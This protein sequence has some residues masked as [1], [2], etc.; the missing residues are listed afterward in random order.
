[1][2][3]VE[4]QWQNFALDLLLLIASEILIRFLYSDYRHRFST[5]LLVQL[6]SL[7]IFCLVVMAF[8]HFPLLL[9]LFLPLIAIRCVKGILDKRKEAIKGVKVSKPLKYAKRSSEGTGIEEPQYFHLSTDLTR[10]PVNVAQ[11][12]NHSDTHSTR[13]YNMYPHPVRKMDSTP[14][15]VQNE[16]ERRLQPTSSPYLTVKVSPRSSPVSRVGYMYQKSA[17]SSNTSTLQKY[18]PSPT[19]T[20]LP[21]LPFS[22]STHDNTTLVASSG[23]PFNTPPYSN[24]NSVPSLIA[25][26]SQ[27]KPPGL[28]NTGNICFLVSVIHCLAGIEGFVSLLL[29]FPTPQ[30]KSDNNL[31]SSL[32]LVI[33][34]CQNWSLSSIKPNKLLLAISSLAPHLVTIHGQSQQD[35]G[36]FLLWLLDA[37]HEMHKKAT[38]VDMTEEKQSLIARL[39]S[40]KDTIQSLEMRSDDIET[41][42]DKLIKLSSVD[43]SILEQE[44]MS[45]IYKMCCGQLFEAREC[46]QC[47]RVSTNI[48]YYTILTL[49]VPQNTN[50]DIRLCFELFSQ[51]ESLNH[52][53]N[54]FRC[55]C[56]IKESDFPTSG[57]RLAC[58]SYLPSHL[59]IQLARFS[60]DYARKQALKNQTP[61]VFPVTGLDLSSFTL[62]S[63]LKAPLDASQPT[64]Y[65]LCGFCVHTGARTT[66]YG[67]YIA[68]SKAKDGAWYR[69]DDNYVSLVNDIEKEIKQP[70]VSQNTYLIFYKAKRH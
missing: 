54:M 10:R 46:Q 28:S 37:L 56:T 25:T 57:S 14:T 21:T 27:S 50:S 38:K 69:F 23:L 29:Q 20:L 1:M 36:E 64:L 12:G 49:P 5:L 59:I 41:Y 65:D 9:V 68:Y 39:K 53:H 2:S 63:K 66:S 55:T 62:N 3:F 67:H 34:Q 48:E 40:E 61:V 42:R 24:M 30:K 52:S 13:M 17:L 47:K 31:I 18:Y 44:N 19:R 32:Q 51:I 70:F 15:R 43:Y 33:Q 6:M 11:Y 45:S 4:L 8:H 16:A 60:Y 58:L 26:R 35:A 22:S 7:V